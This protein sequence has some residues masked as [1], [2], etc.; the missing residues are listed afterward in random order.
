MHSVKSLWQQLPLLLVT[1]VLSVASGAEDHKTLLPHA[2]SL[3][4]HLYNSGTTSCLAFKSIRI[5][6]PLFLAPTPTSPATAK[7]MLSTN[8]KAACSH[9]NGIYTS[10]TA[11]YPQ[12]FTNMPNGQPDF[13][14]EASCLC[15]TTSLDSIIWEPGIYDGYWRSCV[16]WFQTASP[17]FYSASMVGVDLNPCA[18]LGDIRASVSHT[19]GL[20]TAQPGAGVTISDM[21]TP[22]VTG[23]TTVVKEGLARMTRVSLILSYWL[24]LMVYLATT[25]G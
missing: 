12:Y 25:H 22:T 7:P 3:P 24:G 2:F 19:T 8:N 16:E 5:S 6:S 14:H 21:Q 9:W 1:T 17:S 20:A 11:N 13:D 10:C 18:D 23:S 4:C 15:Y